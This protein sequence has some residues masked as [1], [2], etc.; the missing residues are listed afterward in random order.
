[1]MME[2]VKMEWNHTDAVLASLKFA[3]KK[4]NIFIPTR[5]L[6]Q[7]SSDKFYSVNY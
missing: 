5:E 1:M 3:V 2:G 4:I 6:K 7:F